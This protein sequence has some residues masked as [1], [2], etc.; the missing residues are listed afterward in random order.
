MLTKFF[1]PK[2]AVASQ[3]TPLDQER[4]AARV[5]SLSEALKPIKEAV[6][7]V[8]AS[9][10]WV[11]GGEDGPLLCGH[12]PDIGTQ[13]YDV[14]L[15]PPLPSTALLKYQAL[16]GFELSV[17]LL[18]LFSQLNGCSLFGLKIYGVPRSMADNPPLL[19]RLN[20]SPLDIASGRHWRLGYAEAEI[21]DVLFASRNVGGSGQIGYFM[22]PHGAISGRGNESSEA[23]ERCGP[24]ADLTEWLSME[25]ANVR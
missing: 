8:G 23:P 6:T 9:G 21:E 14:V 20:R 4:F 2:L 7:T 13:A 1:K 12:R 5:D 22:S 3:R 16:H 24:W 25:L 19:D 15:F 11:E 18:N 17:H 10:A